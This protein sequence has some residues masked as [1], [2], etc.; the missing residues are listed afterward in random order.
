MVEMRVGQ[1]Q[2]RHGSR[3]VAQ[4]ADGPGQLRPHAGQ[5]GIDDGQA[6]VVFHQVGVD[7]GMFDAVDSLCNVPGKHVTSKDSRLFLHRKGAVY[8]CRQPAGGAC[9][10][11]R[12]PPA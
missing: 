4:F 8:R 6:A 11:A 12:R 9:K 1:H 10:R 2:R 7:V 5:A 3:P